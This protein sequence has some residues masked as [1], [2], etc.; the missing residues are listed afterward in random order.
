MLGWLMVVAKPYLTKAAVAKCRLANEYGICY[1]NSGLYCVWKHAV[2]VPTRPP[3]KHPQV[4][5]I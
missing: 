4:E 3:G 2:K 5:E 1:I